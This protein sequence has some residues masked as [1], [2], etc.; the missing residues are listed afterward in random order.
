MVNDFED[1]YWST[2]C[3]QIREYSKKKN[4]FNFVMSKWSRRKHNT[5][6]KEVYCQWMYGF[7]DSIQFGPL[8]RETHQFT[9]TN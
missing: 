3:S 6:D 2:F 1:F 7:P 5:E 8:E 4:C 9:E